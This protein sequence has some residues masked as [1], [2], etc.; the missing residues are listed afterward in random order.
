MALT[1]TTLNG[2][3]T[4]G[5]TMITLTSGTGIAKK[6]LVRVDGEMMRVTDVSLSPTVQVVRG[7]QGTAG[8]AHNTLALCAYG[9]ASDFVTPNAM[10]AQ[11]YA[12]YSV[13]G[14]ITV[15]TSN[16]FIEINKAGAALMTLAAPGLDQDGL[17]L[18]ITSNTAQAHTITATGLFQDGSTTTDV[19]T[20]AAQK[21]VS[22][23]I[24]ALGGKWNVISVG[25]PVGASPGVTFT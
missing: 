5:A 13:S 22:L 16:Q 6:M 25:N 21:G 3:I 7:Y 24:S 14:A 9:N 11:P 15:P 19:A 4:S 20:F 10:N 1:G 17:Q 2:A 23:V 12:S 18:T 8:V